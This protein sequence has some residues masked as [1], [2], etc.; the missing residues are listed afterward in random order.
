[1]TCKG[2]VAAAP[3]S[4]P[5]SYTNSLQNSCP[6]GILSTLWESH[7]DLRVESDTERRGGCLLA[8][9]KPEAGRQGQ[10]AVVLIR[11]YRYGN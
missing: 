2:E 8:H 4:L 6:L 10:E 7:Q 9:S 11:L 5:Q 3:C 1:M